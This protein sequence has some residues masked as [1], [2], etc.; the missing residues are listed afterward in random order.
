MTVPTSVG[1][2]RHEGDGATST[3]PVG[4]HFQAQADLE[5]IVVNT[6]TDTDTTLTLNTHYTVAGTGDQSGGTVTLSGAYANLSSSYV[7]YVG[8]APALNNSTSFI[9]S[10]KVSN[11]QL[12]IAFDRMSQR[13]I[14]LKT[15]IDRCIKIPVKETPTSANTTLPDSTDRAS[16]SFTWSAAGAPTASTASDA[17]ALS[18]TSIGETI[19]EAANAGAVLDAL[20]FTTFTKTIVDDTT[21]AGVQ[22]TIGITAAAQTVLDDTTVGAMRTTLGLD[23]ASGVITS[24][25]LADAI[26]A[27]LFQARLTLTSATP[28]TTGDVSGAGTIYL[29]P[30]KGNKIATYNG[31]RWKL[32]TL[33]EISLALTATSGS[34]YDVWVYDNS[35]TLTLETT[36]WTNVTTRATALALQD[37][38]YVKSG[39]PTRRYVGTFYAT[40]TDETSDGSGVRHLWNYYNRVQKVSAISLTSATWTYTTAT[41]RQF[42][43]SATYQFDFTAGVA[44]DLNEAEL[45][46]VSSNSSADVVRTVGFGANST[47]S[48]SGIHNSAAAAGTPATTKV[49]HHAMYKAATAAGKYYIALLEHSVATG[50]TTWGD[51]G[52]AV[53]GAYFTSWC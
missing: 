49:K 12:Q 28:V 36:V 3:F 20:G 2:S 27:Q 23:G 9:N 45:L 31:T 34:V 6:T 44:E 37:G 32:H 52:T 29:T 25:D 4:F 46:W 35:G 40:G 24:L 16:R 38:V 26:T 18:V 22:T 21:G 5:V 7:I 39:T 43:G 53:Y 8:L 50:T 33:T 48:F 17:S 30:Y 41:I 10:G 1:V 19:V 51:G 13:I 11:A 14:N 42:N 15:L 47:T